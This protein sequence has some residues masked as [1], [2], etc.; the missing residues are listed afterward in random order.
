M[1]IYETG[2][3]ELVEKNVKS[4]RLFFISNIKEAIQKS[5]VVFN[6][7]GTPEDKKTGKANLEYVFKVAESFGKNLNKYN[8]LS[9]YNYLLFRLV[10]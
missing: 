3:G 1:P 7:V 5:D 10:H 4:G 6:A 8:L 2:L 9:M